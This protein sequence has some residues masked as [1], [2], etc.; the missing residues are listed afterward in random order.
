M[1]SVYVCGVCLT[2]DAECMYV[3]SV[4]LPMNA[5]FVCNIYL[6]ME[7]ECVYVCGILPTHEC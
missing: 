4:Y 6:P 5:V 7:V 3:C 2:M 1:L